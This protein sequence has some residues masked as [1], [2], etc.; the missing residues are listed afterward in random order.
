MVFFLS[1]R[2]VPRRICNFQLILYHIINHTLLYTGDIISFVQ[3]LRTV[4]IIMPIPSAR[5]SWLSSHGHFPVYLKRSL[6]QYRP[7][8]WPLSYH[9]HHHT[10]AY[11]KLNVLLIRLL[12]YRAYLIVQHVDT[13]FRDTTIEYT[14]VYRILQGGVK[15]V[16]L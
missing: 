3:I 12:S 10:Q 8:D 6:F 11:S 14:I 2:V 16:K 13:C 4:I 5:F 15:Q 1:P 7:Q 9:C